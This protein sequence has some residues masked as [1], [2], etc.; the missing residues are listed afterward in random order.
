MYHN[1]CGRG[2]GVEVEKINEELDSLGDVGDS[3]D[4]D[5]EEVPDG[6]H[7][8]GEAGIRGFLCP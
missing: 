7:S 6:V 5:F 3:A 8:F 2:R 1:R 4:S